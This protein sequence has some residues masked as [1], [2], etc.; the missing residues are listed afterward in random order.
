MGVDRV[1]EVSELRKSKFVNFVVWWFL[2]ANW[3]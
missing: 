3:K 2:L 1:D